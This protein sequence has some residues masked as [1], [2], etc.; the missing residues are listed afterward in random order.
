MHTNDLVSIILPIHN[1]GLCLETCLQSLREQTHTNIEIIVVDDNSKDGSHRTLSRFKK[2]DKR[3]KVFRKKKRYGLAISLNRAIKRARGGFIAFMDPHD[4]SSKHRIKKQLQYL[5][6]N[7]KTVAIG[8][9]CHFV[10]EEGKRKQKSIFPLDHDSIHKS[11]LPGL[12]LL[13][14][15]VMVNRYVIPK[16]LLKFNT[17]IYTSLL[18]GKYV[19]FTELFMKLR[20]YGQFANLPQALHMP[21]S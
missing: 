13:Y 15:T 20:Q 7:P 6:Q 18:G 14:D 10:N 1:P 16:D 17:A 5:S 21:V 8:T 9:Q 4:R 19:L 11:L 12:S 3:I 2:L